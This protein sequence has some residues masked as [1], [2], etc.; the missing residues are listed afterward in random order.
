[1]ANATNFTLTLFHLLF[2]FNL[3]FYFSIF[4]FVFFFNFDIFPVQVRTR[5]RI[6]VQ[7]ATPLV[8]PL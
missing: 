6:V 8:I 5:M 7:L 4:R 1:M 2:T 3:L